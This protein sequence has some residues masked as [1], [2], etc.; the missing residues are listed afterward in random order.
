MARRYLWKKIKK[1]FLKYFDFSH[2][3]PQKNS[4]H[5]V[6]PFGRPEGTYIYIYE[7][8]VL[9]YRYVRQEH[10]YIDLEIS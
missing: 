9:L 6:Q 2:E 8:L 5:S 7:C 10:Y 3:C 1:I 4:A